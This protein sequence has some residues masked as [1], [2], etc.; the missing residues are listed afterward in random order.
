MQVPRS[1][2]RAQRSEV[3]G[4]SLNVLQGTIPA[5]IHGH[6][7][8]IA[9]VGTVEH[10][11]LPNP[12]GN[13]LLNGDGMICRLDLSASAIALTMRLAQ[14]ADLVA[15]QATAARPPG[16]PL[17]FFSTGIARLATE[18]GARNFANTA[19]VPMDDGGSVPRLLLCYDAGR[20][21]E[22]DPQTLDVVTPVGGRASWQADTLEDFPFPLVLSPAHPV[23]DPTTGQLFTANYGRS[24]TSMFATGPLSRWARALPVGDTAERV[25]EVLGIGVPAR[26]FAKKA[27]RAL[28]EA[29]DWL[30]DTLGRVPN[31]PEDFTNLIRWDGAGAPQRFRLILNA[32]QRVEIR[33]SIHQV[34]VTEHYAV[35]LD[36]A[37]K[38]GLD[39][40]FNDPV[41]FI[42]L[43]D[44]A[45]RA[46]ST[47]PQPDTTIFYVVSRADLD[48]TGLPLDRDGVPMIR[49]R[50][51]EIPLEA[52]H[53]LVDY[54]DAG[55]RIRLHVAHAP[56]TDLSEWVREY[57]VKATDGASIDPAIHGMM[58][59]GAMDLNRFGQYVIDATTGEVEESQV[60][61]DDELTWAIALYAGRDVLT[62]APHPQKL[63]HLYWVTEGMFDELLTLWVYNLYDDY[64]HRLVNADRI[65]QTCRSGGRRAAIV[66]VDSN[67]FA[68]GD[69]FQLPPSTMLGSMQ[70]VPKASGTGGTDGYLVCT[71]YTDAEN[72]L[73]ILDAAD[74]AAGPVCKLSH[75]QMTVGFSLHTAWLPTVGPRQSTYRVTAD[76]DF[77]VS[78]RDSWSERARHLIDSVVI[79]AKY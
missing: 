33:Q 62:P 73:W 11:G 31:V 64:A 41:P 53:F 57:D 16:D 70:F 66:R 67:P 46:C 61:C 47:D 10:P 79:P 54:D 71:V 20:P 37:F 19:F 18:L 39:Q 38:I 5:D 36:T 24:A 49:A 74:L 51:I 58:A 23:Y 15:D 17:R 55:G 52:D 1:M 69:H 75:P 34:A 77:P 8:F 27:L 48:A 42:D 63:E 4:L 35:I 40:G 2:M 59:V 3:S 29:E 65:L 21:V 26:R 9:P 78:L 60:I 43:P 76:E 44:R 68:I 25:A 50:K 56:A 14:T 13:T 28:G 6:V 45:I 72:Q 22:I 30:M 7:F 32:H 12:S